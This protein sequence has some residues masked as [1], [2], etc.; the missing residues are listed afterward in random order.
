MHWFNGHI[1]EV[2]GTC[3]GKLVTSYCGGILSLMFLVK[4]ESS[5]T[6]H[7]MVFV[8]CFPTL[9]IIYILPMAIG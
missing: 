1:M 4:T 3:D 8:N 5:A 2:A 7:S 6:G 9:I